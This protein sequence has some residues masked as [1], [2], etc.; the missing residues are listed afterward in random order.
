VGRRIVFESQGADVRLDA[1]VLASVQTALV[2]AVRNAVAHGIEPP[3]TRRAAGKP[4]AGQITVEVQRRGRRVAFRCTDDGQGI[5]LEAV[6]RAAERKG[7][8]ATGNAASLVDLLLQGGI[9]TSAAVTEVSGRGIGMDIVR[10]TVARLGGTVTVETNPGK[11]TIF[12]LIVPLTLASAEALLVD[13]AG[14]TVAIPFDAVR[15]ALRISSRDIYRT[16]LGDEMIYD[17]HAIPFT[18]LAPLLGQ[19]GTDF[20]NAGEVSAIIVTGRD[21]V[22]AIGVDRLRGT[23]NVVFRSLPELAP[24]DAIVA[25]ASLDAEG[26]PQLVLDP[27]ALVEAASRQHVAAPVAPQKQ[28]PILIVD[29]SLTT[30]MLEQSILESAGYDVEMATSA[31]EGLERARARE[32]S[33]FLVDVEMPGMDGFSFIERIRSEPALSAIPAILVTSRNAPEDRRRGA[34][35]GAQGYVVK[36][37]FNQAELLSR[38]R[39]LSA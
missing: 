21:E 9:S 4:P 14:A 24:A 28:K 7:I 11:G 36:T 29:D 32:Y 16:A 5:D 13:A 12:E 20:G 39:Q 38:I 33:L 2:Q 34:E 18:R 22:A 26:N 15:H 10:E 6:R 3:G 19:T 37:E 17:G 23:A 1:D 27:V 25:G 8:K 35:A 31:E 30:R